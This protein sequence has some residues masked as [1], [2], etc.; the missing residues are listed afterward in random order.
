MSLG[1]D[2]NIYNVDFNISRYN[3]TNGWV[4]GTTFAMFAPLGPTIP[5]GSAASWGDAAGPYRPFLDFGDAPATYDP[6]PL[7]PACH[8]TLTP[9]VSNQRTRL[10]LG[11]N[12]DVE[13]LKRG[14]T[15]V[16]DNF[17]DG[18]PFV[19]I[20]APPSGS[21]VAQVNVFN[22]TNA[23]ATVIAWLDFNGNGLFDASEACNPLTVPSSPVT[24]SLF[25]NWPSTP[26]S[27]PNGSFTYLRVRITD[28]ASGMTINNSTGYYDIGEVEDYRVV[29]DY[30]SLAVDLIS[31]DAKVE[32][33]SAVELKWSASEDEDFPGYHVQ[34]SSNS[35]DWENIGFIPASSLR[36]NKS[37]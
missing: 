9:N 27:L 11:P 6:N 4:A 2:E 26:S 23:N 17:E 34:R 12:E 15:T 19:P 20:F 33:N 32:N 13:W 31:F 22:N 28:Q 24:Q 36:C 8:D 16:E 1:W 10:R 25:L 30:I 37:L 5:T 7:S 3:G 18:L 14:L 29:V 35:T 21:Y